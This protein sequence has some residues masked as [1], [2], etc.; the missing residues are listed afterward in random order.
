MSVLP[1]TWLIAILLLV[2]LHPRAVMTWAAQLSWP[3]GCVPLALSSSS[4]SSQNSPTRIR[5]VPAQEAP[6]C[7]RTWRSSPRL[8]NK[9]EMPRGATQCAP[10]AQVVRTDDTWSAA[11]ASWHPACRPDTLAG[12][13]FGLPA[14]TVLLESSDH[15]V[16]GC[17][18]EMGIN[19]RY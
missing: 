1:K 4:A 13:S 14:R 12:S 9:P 6:G 3:A 8:R 15:P 19:E 18:P 11:A 17:P 7:A 10:A 2:T 16:F 5:M